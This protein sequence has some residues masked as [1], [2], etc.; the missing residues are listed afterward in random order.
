MIDLPRK[1]IRSL[2]NVALA[3]RPEGFWAAW[4][5]SHIWWRD[6]CISGCCAPSGCVRCTPSF[7]CRSRSF[8][9]DISSTSNP[10]TSR[11]QP[12]SEARCRRDPHQLW[13]GQLELHYE[14][15]MKSYFWKID[16]IMFVKLIRTYLFTRIS[17]KA[18]ILC[19]VTQYKPI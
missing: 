3:L 12:T 17:L 15:L 7:S 5:W 11:P 1:I 13:K 16:A 9:R 10:R 2:Y 6:T 8:G 18:D 19:D 4:T 14:A